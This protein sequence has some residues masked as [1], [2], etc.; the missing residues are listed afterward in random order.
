MQQYAD[1]YLLQ[2]Q[3]TCLGCP[4]HPSSGVLKT[5][6]AVSVTGHRI[7]TAT[8]LQRDQNGTGGCGYSF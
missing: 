1:I 3:S 5:V 7:G 8:F 6:T 4:S 2:N